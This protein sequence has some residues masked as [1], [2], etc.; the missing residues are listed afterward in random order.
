MTIT[1]RMIIQTAR[2]TCG[3]DEV[4][5][6]FTDSS[7]EH[8]MRQK[9]GPGKAAGEGNIQYPPGHKCNG[10]PY[11]RGRPCIGVCLK[12]ICSGKKK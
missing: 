11:G 4:M 3:R 6:V 10:C 5:A 7:F 1:R 12:E 9:P 8:M 2:M